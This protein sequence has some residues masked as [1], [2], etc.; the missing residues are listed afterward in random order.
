[1]KTPLWYAA[2]ISDRSTVHRKE[3]L[4]TVYTQNRYLSCL[5]C[6]FCGCLP[7]WSPL[8]YISIYFLPVWCLGSA[9][10]K[11]TRLRTGGYEIKI[12]AEAGNFCLLQK[13]KTSCGAH[14]ASYSMGI[15]GCFTGVKQLGYEADHSPPSSAEV[16]NVCLCGMC[17]AKLYL[18]LFAIFIVSLFS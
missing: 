11:V 10:G 18:C 12:L 14:P 13:V 9:V 4:K 1:M 6:H 3:Y 2:D 15:R 8:V 17:G 16:K 7:A 5:S